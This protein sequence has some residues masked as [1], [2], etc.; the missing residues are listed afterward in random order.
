VTR[1]SIGVILPSVTTA[2]GDVADRARRAEDIGLDAVFSGDHLAADPPTLDGTVLLA[3]AAAAT[4]RLKIGFGVMVLAL[5]HPA[6]AAKQIASLQHVTGNRL[7]LGVGTGGAV[8]GRAAW[9]AVGI[10]F[11]ERGRRTDAALD[12][13]PGLVAGRPAAG[14]PIPVPPATATLGFPR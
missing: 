13:L 4:V 2:F 1:L 5:R 7:V 11:A 10:P 14:V 12:V 3:T 9:D 6:W 8:H